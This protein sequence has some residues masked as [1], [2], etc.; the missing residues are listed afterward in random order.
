MK[1]DSMNEEWTPQSW[2]NFKISQ[3]PEYTDLTTLEE[4]QTKV[5]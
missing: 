2:K 5:K 3:Q 1:Q 4:V